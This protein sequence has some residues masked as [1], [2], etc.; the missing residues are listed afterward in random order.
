MK[1][2]R[3]R[4]IDIQFMLIMSI[5]YVIPL[6]T[7]NGVKHAFNQDTIFHLSRI[8][9]LQNVFTTP[10]SFNNFAGHGTMIN[11]FYPWLTIYPAYLI[12]KIAG[13]LFLGYNLYY[14]LITWLTMIIAF[15]SINKIKNDHFISICFSIIY[16]FSAYRAIDIFHRASMG[17]A[18]TFVFLPLIFTGCYEIFVG[19]YRSWSWLA[20]G[21]SLTLYTH[22]LSV[23]MISIIIF[24][25]L[26]LTFYFWNYK[27]QRLVSLLKATIL[28]GLLSIGFIVPFLQQINSHRLSTPDGHML[29]GILPS[30]LITQS[31]NNNFN[32]YTIGLLMGIS[33]IISIIF[34]KHFDRYDLFILFVGITLLISTT[35][36][37]PW[38]LLSHTPISKLQ[39]V[40]RIN[41]IISLIFSYTGSIAIASKKKLQHPSG[42]LL[43]SMLSIFI[44]LSGI[45]NYHIS[46]KENITLITARNLETVAS[47]YSH[48]DYSNKESEKYRKDINENKYLINNSYVQP[49]VKYKNNNFVFKINNTSRGTSNLITPIYYYTGQR[50]SVD[51]RT[52]NSRL[53]HMGT[54]EFN[55]SKGKHTIV[56]GYKYTKLAKISILTSLATLLLFISLKINKKG[57]DIYQI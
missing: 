14:L 33:L 46:N 26:I 45:L 42:I 24:I 48:T 10:V 30:D 12:F 17:E 43:I 19:N 3:L 38:S 49:K 8:I 18:V 20:A 15:I 32:N 28:T 23:A 39:F 4:L 35:N 41:A 53:S 29:S 47:N 56:I 44:T 50:V 6:F 5:I 52:V 31:I 36:I 11:I 7:H 55:I 51:N 54:T 21:M 57:D 25:L 16:T 9:G 37:F 13:S 34:I 40:W 2:N 22:L 27:L 1:K